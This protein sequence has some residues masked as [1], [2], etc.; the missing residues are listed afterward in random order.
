M[1]IIWLQ[2]REEWNYPLWISLVNVSKSAI[3]CVFDHICWN[4]FAG[5]DFVSCAMSDIIPGEALVLATNENGWTTIEVAI[6]WMF[7]FFA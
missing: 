4:K 3:F 5:E 1:C 7:S 2:L 6:V